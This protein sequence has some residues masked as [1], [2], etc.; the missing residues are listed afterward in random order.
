MRTTKWIDGE[1]MTANQ[2]DF[3]AGRMEF[4][5]K[6]ALQ[7]KKVRSFIAKKPGCVHFDLVV[8]FGR[9]MA[10]DSTDWLLKRVLIKLEQGQ[11]YVIP[12]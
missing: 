6:A 5:S 3:V 9:K 1:R 8:Q 4:Q 12:L 2:E 10:S 11:Y 7:A